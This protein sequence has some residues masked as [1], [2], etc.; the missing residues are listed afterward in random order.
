[1]HV[2]PIG[3]AY[4]SRVTVSGNPRHARQGVSRRVTRKGAARSSYWAAAPLM[5]KHIM[6]NKA[7]HRMLLC[8][9]RAGVASMS[10]QGSPGLECWVQE[11]LADSRDH[12]EVKEERHPEP[13]RDGKGQDRNESMNKSMNVTLSAQPNSDR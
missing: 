4:A 2:W 1:M 9:D 6:M 13:N 11:V 7:C 5:L 10:Q 12:R 8:A 3:Q